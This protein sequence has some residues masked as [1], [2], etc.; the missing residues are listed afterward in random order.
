MRE[1]EKGGDSNPLVSDRIDPP[2]VVQSK[3]PGRGD[4]C[5]MIRERVRCK[6]VERQYIP[7]RIEG[8]D[9]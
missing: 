8:H 5:V 9:R 1:E 3:P 7:E 4:R 6:K 2:L